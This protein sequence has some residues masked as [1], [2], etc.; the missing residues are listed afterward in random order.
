LIGIDWDDN[1]RVIART[2]TA[3][4]QTR[5][6]YDTLNRR[7]AIIYPDG[8]S[9]HFGRDANGNIVSVHDPNGNVMIQ[10]FDLVNRLVKRDIQP[11]NGGNPQAEQ[12]RYNGLGRL[13]AGINGTATVTRRFDSLSRILAEAQP[14]G[15]IQYA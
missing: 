3:G 14:N 10:Q 5:Y 7:S 13:V 9:R 1:G 12:F 11:S 4:H 2:N 15:T 8:N 6:Q